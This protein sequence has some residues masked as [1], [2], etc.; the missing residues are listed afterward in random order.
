MTALQRY[1]PGGKVKNIILLLFIAAFLSGCGVFQEIYRIDK[2]K[3]ENCNPC[4]EK[5]VKK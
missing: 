1:F 2:V 5:K 4:E 3:Q